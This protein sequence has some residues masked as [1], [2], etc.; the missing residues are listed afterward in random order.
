M[1][2]TAIAFGNPY[3]TAVTIIVVLSSVIAARLTKKGDL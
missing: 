1:S 3:V 2:F